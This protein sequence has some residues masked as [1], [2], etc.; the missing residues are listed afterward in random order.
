MEI[1]SITDLLKDQ[2]E[3]IFDEWVELEDEFD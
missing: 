1:E 2:A 3:E